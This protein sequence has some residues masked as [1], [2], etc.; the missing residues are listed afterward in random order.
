MKAI[1]T[2]EEREALD[3]TMQQQY[4]S[5]D[6]GRWILQV[7]SVDGYALE[8]VT[9]LKAALSKERTLAREASN[10]AKS[11][12]GMDAEAARA[13]L[14]KVSEMDNWTPQ[15]KVAEQIER[16]ERQLVAKHEK[17]LADSGAENAHLR[18]QLD[19]HLIEAA[20]VNAL[21]KHKGNIELLLPHVKSMTRVEQDG[22]GNF[23]ARVVDQDGHPRISMKQ[24][25]QD[26]MT[27]DELVGSLR[28]SDTFAPAFAGSGATGSGATGNSAGSAGTNGKH[29]LRWEDSRDPVKY[30]QAKQRADAAGAQLEIQTN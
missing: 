19:K 25:S 7:D 3:E 22:S 8:D 27:I 5:I 2:T 15:D 13:A 20:A 26:P 24:G 23:V 16:R 18:S 1:I 12:E 29:V 4:E 10:L 6:D 9:G 30:R 11:F 21:N 17:A 28:Q 14:E